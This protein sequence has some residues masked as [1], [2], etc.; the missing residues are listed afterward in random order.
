MMRMLRVYIVLLLGICLLTGCTNNES[1][2]Q[3]INQEQSIQTEDKKQQIEE[4]KE[5]QVSEDD[6]QQ[7]VEGNE[8][9]IT[10]DEES[11]AQEDDII[12]NDLI[13]SEG[14]V[15]SKEISTT[16]EVESASSDDE[17][18]SKEEQIA[19]ES[20]EPREMVTVSEVNVRIEPSLTSDILATLEASST[21]T[22]TG[23]ID[24]W[25]R[26]DYKG[27]VAY[28]YAAYLK[29]ELELEDTESNN[30]FVSSE[31]DYDIPGCRIVY[32]TAA[33]AP[34]IVI[35]AGHQEKGNY[36]KE[37][38]GPGATEKKAKVSSGTQGRWTGLVEYKLNLKVAI[39]LRDAL[40][41]KGYNIIMI[42]ETNEVDIS[43][44]ERA[45][46]AN[47][48]N[49]DAFI[50]IHAN[51]SED[52]SSQGMMTIC[53]TKNNPYCGEL[54][55]DSYQLSNCI[56]EGMLSTTGAKDKGIWETDTM[57]GINWCSVP[58]TIIEMGYMTN[59]TEDELL[60]TDDYQN[61]IVDGI[62]KGLDVYLNELD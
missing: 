11:K 62:V 30:D 53:Q 40:L 51:G 24:E 57:S 46:I 28:M 27:A 37:A 2:T 22:C 8:Q 44:S 48:I 43:N 61:K 36:N 13:N 21:V 6:G 45:A 1:K 10:G 39:K 18:S 41:T 34:W 4:G 32:K 9:Q 23:S 5:Q 26:I 19:V 15:D 31:T 54:Y 29:E 7:I 50:R 17:N 14:E 55:E 3:E 20:F 16:T 12:H 58:V 52:A 42:R 33:D 35:D 25:Y 60:A 47:D 49:A 38:I 56:L 59:K